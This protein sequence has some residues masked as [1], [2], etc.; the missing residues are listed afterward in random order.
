MLEGPILPQAAL[1]AAVA[2]LSP[3][4]TDHALL[5]DP[6]PVPGLLRLSA[7]QASLG[8]SPNGPLLYRLHSQ[9]LI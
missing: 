2:G 4:P 7:A 8:A 6:A 9:L 1:A 3:L 5:G